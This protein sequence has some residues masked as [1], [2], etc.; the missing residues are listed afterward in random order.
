MFGKIDFTAPG[1]GVSR[2]DLNPRDTR[3]DINW[4]LSPA[5]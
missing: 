4:I 5:L 1:T 2:V 3:E